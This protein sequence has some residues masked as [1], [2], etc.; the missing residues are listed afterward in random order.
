VTINGVSYSYP[1]TTTTWS[2]AGTSG[3]STPHGIWV[4]EAQKATYAVLRCPSDPKYPAGGTYG[5]WGVTSYVANWN[6]WGNSTGDGSAVMGFWSRQ[7]LGLWS[8]PERFTD[9]KDG[10]S[11]TVLFGE[12][13]SV[14][15]GL[16]RIALYS[17]GYHNFGLTPTL[18]NVTFDTNSPDYPSGVVNAPNGLPNTLMFQQQ[19]LPIAYTQCP[20][21]ADCCDRWVAQTPHPGGMTIGMADASVRS[22]Q[23][24]VSQTTWNR[25]L[26]A[27][28]GQVP[29]N[30]W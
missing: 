28:D 23:R 4:P 29:G 11:S 10:L 3:T 13:Y 25:L 16:E 17:W 19:P 30:D 5:G 1:Q 15:D 2:V 27:R 9:I 21:G 14:C 20:A 8:P 18:R 6:A 26:Q 7:H 12:A 24:G 22:S